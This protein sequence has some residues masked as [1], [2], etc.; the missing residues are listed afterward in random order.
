M[1]RV[2]HFN[3]V[4]MNDAAGA[5]LTDA[6]HQR[7]SLYCGDADTASVQIAPTEAWGTAVV[8]VRASNTPDGP[9]HDLGEP[10]TLTAAARM[11]PTFYLGFAF[12]ALVL[13]TP[14]GAAL[15]AGVHICLRSAAR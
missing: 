12:V 10:V 7:V 2:E 11:T 5:V 3:A 1:V 15:R 4:N 8:A 13:T 14:E 6:E 9:W